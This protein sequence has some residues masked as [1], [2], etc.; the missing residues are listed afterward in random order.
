MIVAIKRSMWGGT[1]HVEYRQ[2]GT[3]ERVEVIS[4]LTFGINAPPWS[5]G[6]TRDSRVRYLCEWADRGANGFHQAEIRSDAGMT[7][8]LEGKYE[9][10]PSR[11]S[12]ME[13]H[14]ELMDGTSIAIE[15]HLAR[16]CRC[17]YTLRRVAEGL[18]TRI[19]FC[20]PSLGGA[21]AAV[22][23]SLSAEMV[24]LIT[25]VLIFDYVVLPLSST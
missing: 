17:A 11:K 12:P 3:T 9:F 14:G 2:R 5:Y 19:A 7:V 15:S 25:G 4:S 21:T 20:R 10:W 18:E 13:W 16:I 22:R 24:E 1:F 23:N 6:W 8:R